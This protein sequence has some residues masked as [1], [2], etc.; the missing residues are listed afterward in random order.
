MGSEKISVVIIALN[1]EVLLSSL[2][3]KI[4][5]VGNIE[6]IVSD[7]GSTDRTCEVSRKYA[8]KVVRSEKGRGR[9]LNCGAR[10][11]TGDILLFLHADSTLPDNFTGNIIK[12]F[13]RPGVVGGAFDFAIDSRRV[14][15][16]IISKAA[17]LRSRFLKM[18]YGDQGIFVKR[19]VFKRMKGFSD[20][21]LMEDVD[22]FKRLR[23]EG[24]TTVMKDKIMASA[25]LWERRGL[26]KTTL[27]NWMFVTLYLM[28]YSPAKLYQRYYHH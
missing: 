24:K 11:A 9:Q 23:K 3:Q 16:R 22:F 14:G 1:E 20:I 13:E 15:C 19:E 25:R 26:I 8:H 27:R 12:S 4:S 5:G 10:C 18:P 2:L 28:G 7:G 21:H 17:S 6:I